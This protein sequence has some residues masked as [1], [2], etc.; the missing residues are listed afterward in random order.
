V[1][2]GTG[3]MGWGGL[4]EKRKKIVKRK[5]MEVISAPLIF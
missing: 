3:G 4:F 1:K 5:N 2:K